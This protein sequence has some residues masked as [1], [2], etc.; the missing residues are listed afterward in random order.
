[1]GDSPE[2]FGAVF[3]AADLPTGRAAEIGADSGNMPCSLS[4]RRF[5]WQTDST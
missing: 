3:C 5:A 1:M 4:R 2:P